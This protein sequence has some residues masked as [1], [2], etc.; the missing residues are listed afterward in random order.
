MDN[1]LTVLVVD[2]SAFARS[3]ISK[4]LKSDP[5]I[6][7]VEIARD[8]EEALAKLKTVAPDVITMDVQMPRLDGLGALKK[9][10]RM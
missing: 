3:M 10:S 2:D 6:G 8:G 4:K 1:G 5:D 7:R 9:H